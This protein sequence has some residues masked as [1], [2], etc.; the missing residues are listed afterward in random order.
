MKQELEF[1]QR[2]HN[3]RMRIEE[4][5]DA[6][7]NKENERLSKVHF[8][9]FHRLTHGNPDGYAS[10]DEIPK[11]TYSSPRQKVRIFYSCS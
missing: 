8:E 4:R 6:E 5:E 3:E 2:L 11:W 1:W 7:W 9:A 10:L